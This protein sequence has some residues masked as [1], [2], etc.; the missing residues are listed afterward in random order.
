MSVQSSPRSDLWL[1]RWRFEYLDGRVKCGQ[2]NRHG[3]TAS[4][5]AWSQTKTG[6]AYSCIEGKEFHRRESKIFVRCPADKFINFQWIAAV[7]SPMAVKGSIKKEGD[8]LGLR[9]LSLDTVSDVYIH[10][11]VESKPNTADYSKI[12]LATF[13]R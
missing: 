13:G 5:Q 12:H 2:W 8:M 4:D 6:L 1:L 9:L 7:V 3:D 10:G 11:G